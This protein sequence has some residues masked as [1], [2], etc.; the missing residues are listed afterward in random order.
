MYKYIKVYNLGFEEGI[1]DAYNDINSERLKMYKNKYDKQTLS[2]IYDIGYIDGYR[3]IS[4]VIKK[5]LYFN[6]KI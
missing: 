2:K 1:K 4:N 5:S 6:K 3:R